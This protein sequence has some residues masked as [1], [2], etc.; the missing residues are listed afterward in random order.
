[1]I[2]GI[3]NSKAQV[4]VSVSDKRQ[5]L[6][7]V[8]VG[9]SGVGKNTLLKHVV[10]EMQNLRQLPTF[11][12]RGPRQGEQEGREHYFISVSEFKR[13]AANGEMVEWQQVHAGMFYGTPLKDIEKA[14]SANCDLI[15]DIDVLG[16][17][18]LRSVYADNTVLVFIQPPDRETLR[19]RLEKRGEETTEQIEKR[20]NRAEMEMQ[21]API[22]DYLILNDDEAAAADMLRGIILAERSRRALVNLRAERNLPRHKFA[23]LAAAL[24][25]HGG[26][27]LL[28]VEPPDVP[29]VHLLQGEYPHEAALRLLTET[30]K[31]ATSAEQLLPH[32]PDSHFV[33]PASV[34][35]RQQ[36]HY[37]QLVFLY[38]Y[39]LNERI[40]PPEGW[41]WLPID[42]AGLPPCVLNAV[43]VLEH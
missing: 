9:P 10:K 15:A 16:A 25:I 7:F 28:R 4:T 41:R 31:T 40:A 26:E 42:E 17:T 21:Y 23:Y 37:Q 30:F 8:L 35:L 22:C 14:I 5:G 20:L 38:G 12:T 19:R 33:A 34:E 6:L 27:A 18:A 43:A 32:A 29:A 24:P 1:M 11:T 39:R 13:R 2:L 36:L 3:L